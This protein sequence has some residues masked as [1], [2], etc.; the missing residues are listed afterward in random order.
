MKI[1]L[2]SASERRQRILKEMGYEFEVM[3]ADIDEKAIRHNDPRELVLMLARAKAE[4][5]LSKIKEPALL[6]TSDQ[7]VFSN[8]KILE[9]PE[10]AEEVRNNLESFTDYPP[11]TITSVVVTNTGNGKRVEGV[12]VAKVILKPIPERVILELIKQDKVFDLAGG[13]TIEEP[14]LKDYIE[15][16]EGEKESVIGLPRVLTEKLIREVQVLP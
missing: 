2:G 10:S 1:I 12:N 11:E 8:G 7:V 9:K 4:A 5:L 15:R 3:T 13:F 14:L 6:I 16:I